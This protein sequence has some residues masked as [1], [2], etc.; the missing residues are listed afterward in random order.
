MVKL[1]LLLLLIYPEFRGYSLMVKPT[2]HNSSILV[3]FHVAL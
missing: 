3:Q 2:T 1:L